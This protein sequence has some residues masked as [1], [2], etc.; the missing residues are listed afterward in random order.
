LTRLLIRPR[1]ALRG[2]QEYRDYDAP[3]RQRET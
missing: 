2:D 3:Q 1:E